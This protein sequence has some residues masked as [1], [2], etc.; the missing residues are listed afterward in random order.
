M[1]KYEARGTEAA[2][3]TVGL[4]QDF[5]NKHFSP[6]TSHYR[7][8]DAPI[9]GETLFIP[10]Y[11]SNDGDSL[12]GMR[13]YE[14]AT[15]VDTYQVSGTIDGNTTAGEKIM[16][17]LNKQYA[18]VLK[19]IDNDK[20]DHVKNSTLGY[21]SNV[22]ESYERAVYEVNGGKREITR[23]LTRLVDLQNYPTWWSVSTTQRSDKNK[24]A[25]GSNVFRAEDTGE[26]MEQD[27]YA[28]IIRD[29][30]KLNLRYG[31]TYGE[32]TYMG[33]RA[34]SDYLEK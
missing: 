27:N 15:L 8:D 20:A 1:A 18:H 19:L 5:V 13:P 23:D 9:S 30:E 14:M 12:S 34:A 2:V 25:A 21:D 17:P 11:K 28:V 32:K 31:V 6:T 33:F 4:L 3:V 10:V 29:G 26:G 7:N 16:L 22:E 24:A